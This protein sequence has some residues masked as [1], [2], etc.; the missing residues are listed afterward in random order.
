LLFL[1]SRYVI[2]AK[3]CILERPTSETGSDCNLRSPLYIML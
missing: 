2:Y 3:N 1:I